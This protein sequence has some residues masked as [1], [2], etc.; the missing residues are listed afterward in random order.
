MAFMVKLKA[1]SNNRYL[2][3]VVGCVLF[4]TGLNEAGETIWDDITSMNV[5]A[6]HGIMV[7][8]IFQTLQSLPDI[9]SG[10]NYFVD[11]L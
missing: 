7:F 8:G 2:K 10:V 5:G 1:F 6:H 4:F 9:F 3:L 11:D